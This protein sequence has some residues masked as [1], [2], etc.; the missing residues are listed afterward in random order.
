MPKEQ[1]SAQ[2]TLLVPMPMPML[3]PMRMLML[4]LYSA[5]LPTSML[6]GARLFVGATAWS[7]AGAEPPACSFGVSWALDH[8]D[9]PA[10]ERRAPG[11]PVRKAM[12]LGGEAATALWGVRK[13]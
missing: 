8:P 6:V 2:R 7:S 4:M 11:K 12:G 1:T 5:L 9:P 10:S 13:G 3:M